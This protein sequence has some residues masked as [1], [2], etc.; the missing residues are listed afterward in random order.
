M[1]GVVDKLAKLST[2]SVVSAVIWAHDLVNWRDHVIR[3]TAG[4]FWTV[5]VLNHRNIN[6]INNMRA[7]FSSANSSR[8][9]THSRCDLANTCCVN[10]P[11]PR[12]DITDVWSIPMNL[13][14]LFERLEALNQPDLVTASALSIEV[15]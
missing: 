12:P 1:P 9:Q 14:L 5:D 11:R 8:T 13:T 10:N 6:L 15:W 4:Q 2:H 3:N 7:V